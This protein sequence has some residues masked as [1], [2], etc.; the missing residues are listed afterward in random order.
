MMSWRLCCRWC[1]CLTL[2]SARSK[3]SRYE[4][5]LQHCQ[6]LLLAENNVENNAVD[7]AFVHLA[8]VQTLPSGGEEARSPY[9]KDRTF[10]QAHK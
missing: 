3:D 10:F 9:V 5:V 1:L 4:Q 8:L 2:G 6:A 7:I